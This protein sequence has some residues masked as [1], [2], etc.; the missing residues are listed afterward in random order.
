MIVVIQLRE[1]GRQLAA[2]GSRACDYNQRPAG[3]NIL[4]GPVAGIA[5][6][7]IGIRRIPR[8]GRMGIDG[9]ISAFQLGFEA[10]CRRLSGKPRNNYPAYQKPPVPQIVYKFPRVVVVGN[11]K[12]SLSNPVFILLSRIVV[13][14]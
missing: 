3:L 1:G 12:V 7:E 14:S 13:R 10:K 2:A 5:D 4:I 8:G 6:D 9:N 11:P